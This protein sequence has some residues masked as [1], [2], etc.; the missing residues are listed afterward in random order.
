MKKENKKEIIDPKL[1]QV[2]E[3]PELKERNINN[4]IKQNLNYI[5]AGI[6]VI[7]IGV[8]VIVFLG[9][10]NSKKE[11]QASLY[12]SR[13]YT[14]IEAQ[15]Y[16][17]ALKGDKTKTVRGEE[18]YGLEYIVNNYKGTN[19]GKLASVFAGNCCLQI[20]QPQK[21]IG[22]FEIGLKSDD[23][24]VLQGAN[25]G[26]GCAY[27][28]KKE[29]A[30]AAE[31]YSKASQYAKDDANRAR[32]LLFSAMCNEQAK[33]MDIAKEEYTKVIN[34]SPE[35]EYSEIAKASLTRLGIVI[36]L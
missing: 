9:N 32:Y 31:Y 13:I 11:N 17:T 27:E 23:E 29:Y 22:Y 16:K 12:L 18:L 5:I 35:S 10:S 15:D 8:L 24:N 2:K 6:A 34:I 25:A 33:K 28:N 1:R 3:T 7:I 4:F 19:A 21:A 26:L 36:D 20:N 14:Y 30:K